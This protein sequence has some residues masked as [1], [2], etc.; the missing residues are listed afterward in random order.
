[1]L[2]RSHALHHQDQA[3]SSEDDDRFHHHDNNSAA[4]HQLNDYNH[5]ASSAQ[6]LEHHDDHYA[7]SAQQLQH[8]DDH[9]QSPVSLCGRSS[10]P[11]VADVSRQGWEWFVLRT[12]LTPGAYLA[13]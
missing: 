3:P 10:R 7:R 1:M 2:F 13:D 12:C 4:V 6:Q 8:H 5:Y 11:V 9:H